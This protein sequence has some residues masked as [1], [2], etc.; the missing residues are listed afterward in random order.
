MYFLD[1]ACVIYM[2]AMIN[3][4]LLFFIFDTVFEI[5]IVSSQNLTEYSDS[6]CEE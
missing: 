5:N 6:E 2:V 4:I 3:T 1:V